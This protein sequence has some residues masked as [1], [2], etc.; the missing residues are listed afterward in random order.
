MR[1]PMYRLNRPFVQRHSL[2]LCI[3]WLA[4]G[5]LSAKPILDN[6]EY[7][8]MD[9]GGIWEGLRT[10]ERDAALPA[11]DTVSLPHSFNE[12]DAVNPYVPYYQG[13]GWYRRTLEIDNPYEQGRILLRFDG[14]GQK[15]QVYIEDSFIGEHV[16]GYDEFHF[17][18][19]E[20]VAKH[21]EDGKVRLLVRCDN[22]RD[23]EMIPSDLSDFN[24]YGGL[25]RPVHLLYQPA[26]GAKWPR[27]DCLVDEDGNTG[28]AH[29]RVS[30][31]NPLRI[32]GRLPVGLV[33]RDPEGA[34][35]YQEKAKL[36]LIDRKGPNP[37]IF[38]A[39][40]PSPEL[41]SP[42]APSLY[43]WELTS[44]TPN[45]ESYKQSGTIGFRHFHF[46]EK[47][48]FYLNGERLLLRGTHRHED[49]AGLAAAMLPDLLR[50]E[51]ALMK[52]IGVNFI[53]LGHYQQS[54]E[55]LE[56]CDELGLLVWEEIPWCRGGLGGETYREQARRMLRNMIAQHRHHPSVI[57]WGLG[58]ENDWPGDFVDFDKEAVRDFMKELHG[59]SH[60]CD[61]YRLTAIRR[62]AFC[63][64]V[65]D[66][67]S[68]SIW[69]GWYR[70]KYTDYLEVSRREM[71]TV[72]HFLHVEWGASHHARRHS[73]DPDRGLGSIQSGDADERS[74]DFLMTGGSARVSKDGDWSETYACNLIDW[75]LKEQEKMPWLT[76]T[77]YWPFKDFST[78]IRPENPVPY[79]NQK[80][81]VERDLTPKESFYVFKSYW[82]EE[83]MV[84][85]YG[86]TWPVRAGAAGERKMLKTYSNCESVELFLNGQSL[87]SRERDSE[88]FPAAGLR[89]VTPFKKGINT[90][91]AV[92]RKDGET[93]IDELTFEYQTEGWGEPAQL[94]IEQIAETDESAT[95]EV[96][97]LDAKGVRCL[98]GKN[99]V[100]FS[101][102]GD[103]EL[104]A[105][106]GTSITARKVQLYN[107]RAQISVRKRGGQSWVSVE[108]EGIPTAFI[109]IK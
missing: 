14:A 92:G 38:K 72:D 93:I 26:V 89:W 95:I 81:V 50:K 48:P 76:G 52:E 21:L 30:A 43:S 12:L 6:W 64:D 9:L 80:G 67:Y 91:K 90:V 62:C 28:E 53:R 37:H 44:T 54:R 3:A 70:G 41:W 56:L 10:N 47:G 24:L 4:C 71:E 102:V 86:H 85:I 25:Y 101:L 49:H 36:K 45:G 59:I 18:I 63:A 13:P 87:G 73:E 105:D 33:I 60:A 51:I 58:N 94:R 78:P 100:E 11:W 19:T 46:E 7:T 39:V 32:D 23:L 68:P 65:V 103:G 99:F 96:Y 16:G 40:V 15:T 2:L 108:S 22:S 17:D 31:Y 106:L 35:V 55:V 29:F 1:I 75:H 27:I 79:V 97:A 69:A 98:D 104:I 77:A 8:R 82:T 107:G 5:V 88:D 20:A 57:L 61:P 66:V 83:P 42:E 74:G 34:V 109:S 84:R